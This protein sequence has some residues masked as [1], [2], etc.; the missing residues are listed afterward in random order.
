M[1]TFGP[2]LLVLVLNLSSRQLSAHS[3]AYFV[4]MIKMTS[5]CGYK[6]KTQTNDSPFKKAFYD[7]SVKVLKHIFCCYQQ[8]AVTCDEVFRCL[9]PLTG[10]RNLALRCQNT[11]SR[12][13]FPRDK[14]PRKSLWNLIV[15]TCESILLSIT[16]WCRFCSGTFINI[17]VNQ[18]YF[19]SLHIACVLRKKSFF[20]FIFFSRSSRRKISALSHSHSHVSYAWR[21]AF[22]QVLRTSDTL[23][24]KVMPP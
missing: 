11:V 6:H 20:P 12:C 4:S 22:H 10:I 18:E 9:S 24:H 16:T 21:I 17:S 1:S 15:A 5:I 14:F 13:G 23:C 3:N 8:H 2:F 7:E 19:I